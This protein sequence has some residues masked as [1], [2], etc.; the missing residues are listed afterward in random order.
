MSNI[1]LLVSYDGSRYYGFQRQVGKPTVQQKLEDVLTDIIG[2]PIQITA[3]GRTD[4]GVHAKAQTVNFHT[5]STLFP[6]DILKSINEKLPSDIAVW[7]AK[8]VSD[9]FHSRYNVLKK[10][11]TYR[12]NTSGHSNVFERKFVF[13]FYDSLDIEKMREAAKLLMGTHDFIG[14]SS[15]KKPKKSTV[16]KIFDIEMTEKDGELDITYTASGYLHN[17]VRI[18]TGTLI[19]IGTGE[20]D[21]SVIDEVFET[22]DRSKAGFTAP[23]KGLIMEYALY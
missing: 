11:Y 6:Q 18:I 3:S 8:Y 15:V 7:D 5:D 14:F 17:M 22:G 23:A 19:E 12:I 13:D 4:A 16:R 10:V 20:K 9:R 2:S 1:R 21:I